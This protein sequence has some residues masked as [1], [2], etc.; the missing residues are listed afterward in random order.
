[1]RVVGGL[2]CGGC[3]GADVCVSRPLVS[4]RSKSNMAGVC[5]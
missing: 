1:M 5:M 2:V 4:S 3:M